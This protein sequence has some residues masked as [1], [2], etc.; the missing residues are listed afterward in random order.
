MAQVVQLW[1]DKR[2][3]LFESQAKA[4][5][6]DQALELAQ[7]REVVHR[8][9]VKAIQARFGIGRLRLSHGSS[10]A[11][12]DWLIRAWP[13]LLAIGV[14]YRVHE[15]AEAEAPAPGERARA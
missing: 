13:E 8:L 2:G 5:A 9:F 1:R 11:L 15:L 10:A 12:A 14:A 4:D 7:R 3:F 6:A